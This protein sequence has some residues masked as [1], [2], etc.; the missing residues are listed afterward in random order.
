MAL[1]G[2][3]ENWEVKTLADISLK[4]TVI[5]R[6]E[7]NPDTEFLYLDI[8]GVNNQTNKIESHKTYKW[9]DAPSRAQQIIKKNDVLFS[10]VRTYLKNIAFVDNE[11][12]DG[13]IAS[14]GFTVIR[15]NGSA[16]AKY[17]FYYS[18]SRIFLRPL[19]DLQTG[20]S[21]PAVRDKDV[22]S[23]PIPVPPIEEQER[24]VARIEELFSELDAGVQSLKHAQ[25][26]LKTYRQSVLKWAFEGRLTNDNWTEGEL[27]QG[28]EHKTLGDVAVSVEYGSAAKSKKT[29][30]VPVL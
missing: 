10:T 30:K 13:Q 24:I 21:Y 26:Q 22:F 28:W 16:N 3:P 23:Q 27:P 14:S 17:I 25:A 7:Q 20:S 11:K 12:Y 29:G 4:A 9:K 8:G 18:I 6:K 19:N 5:K 2:L 15:V 1:N